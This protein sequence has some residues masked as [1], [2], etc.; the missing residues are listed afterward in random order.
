MQIRWVGS[1]EP[2]P[3]QASIS[4]QP[5]LIIDPVRLTPKVDRAIYPGEEQHFD[6]AARFDS[7]LECYG[8]SNESYFSVPLWRNPNW[9]IPSGCYLIKVEISSSSKRC[10]GV[11]RLVNDAE[12]S[13]FRLENPLPGDPTI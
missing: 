6:V 4:G 2:V 12:T 7:E 10:S 8:W 11:F 3:L 9:K 13:D 5:L 1:P